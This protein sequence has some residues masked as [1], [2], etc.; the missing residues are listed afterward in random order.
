MS[1]LLQKGR[2][3]RNGDDGEEEVGRGDH[4]GAEAEHALVAV[5]IV[6]RRKGG[7]R[8]PIRLRCSR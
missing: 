4:E 6:L 1:P 3:E 2:A 8:D 7:I 5:P